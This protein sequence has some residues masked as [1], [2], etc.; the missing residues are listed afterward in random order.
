MHTDGKSPRRDAVASV[1]AEALAQ[2]DVINVRT[3]AAKV[4]TRFGHL[5]IAEQ[6]IE[7]I[8]L[9]IAQRHSVAV[10]FDPPNRP[11]SGLSDIARA[12]SQSQ[13]RMD[14]PLAE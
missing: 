12:H 9:Q 3:I 14:M 13:P 1:V 7:T 2:S 11:A 5:A 4:H 6:D 8:V 10:Q